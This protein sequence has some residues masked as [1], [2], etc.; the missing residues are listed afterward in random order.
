MRAREAADAPEEE[1][2]T[3]LEQ[4][5]RDFE[6]ENAYGGVF[7]DDGPGPGGMLR[8]QLVHASGRRALPPA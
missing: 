8:V 1:E 2:L 5:Q 3:P 4:L 7:V 6:L